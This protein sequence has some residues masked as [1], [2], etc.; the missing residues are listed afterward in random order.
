MVVVGVDEV[1]FDEVS[2][3]NA[4]CLYNC[5]CEHLDACT[6][7]KNSLNYILKPF[8]IKKVAS[9]SLLNNE[10]KNFMI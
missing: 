1:S 5:R 10:I 6:C 9:Y 2:C 8:E 7:T 4:K 3:T